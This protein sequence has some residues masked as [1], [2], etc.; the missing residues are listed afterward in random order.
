LTGIAFQ[1]AALGLPFILAGAIKIAYDFALLT[2][3]RKATLDG[4]P[5]P[6]R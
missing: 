5:L 1:L 2:A 3:F 6:T 4:Q